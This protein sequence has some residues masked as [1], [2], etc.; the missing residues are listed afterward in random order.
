MSNGSSTDWRNWRAPGWRSLDEKNF[1]DESV[2]FFIKNTSLRFLQIAFSERKKGCLRYDNDEELTEIKIADQYA[3]QL[4]ASET[5]PAIIAVRGPIA[6]RNI[7]LSHGVQTMNRRIVGLSCISR[8]GLEADQIASDVFNLFKYFRTTLMKFG[9]FSVKSLSL[10][11]EQLVEV[12]GEPKLFLV[13]VMIECQVQDRW[14]LEPKSAAELRKIVL[15]E[16]T[17]EEIID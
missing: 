12:D 5:K 2:P 14:V 6:W 11:S 4:D 13:P 8:V 7:G 16:L 15:D 9:F 10:G 3:Y 1:T 17:D